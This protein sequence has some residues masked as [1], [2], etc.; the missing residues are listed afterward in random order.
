MAAGKKDDL[1]LQTTDADYTTPK[2]SLFLP[3][4]RR[5]ALPFS[6]RVSVR[7]TLAKGEKERKKAIPSLLLSQEGTRFLAKS[8]T[9]DC[10]KISGKSSFRHNLAQGICSFQ[11]SAQLS[12]SMVDRLQ[13]HGLV[14]RSM[15]DEIQKYVEEID[16]RMGSDEGCGVQLDRNREMRRTTRE[17]RAV[18]TLVVVVIAQAVMAYYDWWYRIYMTRRRVV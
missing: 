7:A 17:R 18:A 1:T 3:M 16:G 11:A 2:R 8:G 6:T 14:C 12:H 10:K 5:S 15:W 9:I 13:W 4:G